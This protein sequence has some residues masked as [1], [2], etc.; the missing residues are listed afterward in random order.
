M[1]PPPALRPGAK[2]QAFYAGQN[3]F[4]DALVISADH[5]KV[6]VRFVGYGDT[7]SLPMSQIRS[8][9]PLPEGWMECLDEESGYP[10]YLHKDG[11]SSW[12]RPSRGTSVRF[13]PSA[14]QVAAPPWEHRQ[15]QPQQPR[16]EFQQQSAS[17]TALVPANIVGG[18]ARRS[19]RLAIQQQRAAAAAAAPA[20][21]LP[22][23]A[24]IV[25]GFATSSNRAAMASMRRQQA[26]AGPA[27]MGVL[28]GSINPYR[29]SMGRQQQRALA[30]PG[31][32]ASKRSTATRRQAPPPAVGEMTADQIRAMIRDANMGMGDMMMFGG[33]GCGVAGC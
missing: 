10:Y 18:F 3:A 1:A 14:D 27:P 7:A 22:A 9:D 28:G 29:N 24:S 25:G 26:A 5:A 21:A 11:E 30:L 8:V 15:P 13:Q 23:A 6:K 12:T 16:R 31:G 2:V 19:N 17:E 33:C 32:F 4:F 20:P